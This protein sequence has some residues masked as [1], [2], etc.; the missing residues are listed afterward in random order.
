MGGCRTRR[1][2]EPCQALPRNTARRSINVDAHDLQ[3]GITKSGR[4]GVGITGQDPYLL[5]VTHKR[6]SQ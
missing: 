2:E 3:L 6:L 5:A 1:T 4:R